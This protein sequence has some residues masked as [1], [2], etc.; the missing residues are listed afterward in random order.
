MARTARLRVPLVPERADDFFARIQP[1]LKD[2]ATHVY[3]DTSF[4]MWLTTIG[5]KSRSELIKWLETA[6]TKR[7]HVPVW[8][9]HEY[10][11]HHSA[12]TIPTMLTNCTKK[13]Q[14]TARQTYRYLRPFLDEDIDSAG[15]NA[16]TLQTSARS[17]LTK[18]DEIARDVCKWERNYASHASEI[19]TLINKITLPNSDVF[20]YM[21]DIDAIGS[22]RF[23]G[24]IPPGFEDRHKKGSP[25]LA[26]TESEDA[27]ESG[28]PSGSN[29][30]G[31]L[32]LWKE[33]LEHAKKVRAKHVVILTNDRKSDWYS[34]IIGE[35]RDRIGGAPM[36]RH[37]KA[38]P[39]AHHM[40][41]YEAELAAGIIDVVL[42]DSPYLGEFL[43]TLPNVRAEGFSDVALL[44]ELPSAQTK[45]SQQKEMLSRAPPTQPAS[46][47]ANDGAANYRTDVVFTL[48][49]LRRALF[50]S[51][52]P[53]PP[54]IAMALEMAR[55]VADY[56]STRNPVTS[57][58][59]LGD[60]DHKALVHFARE[61]H[62]RV[63]AGEA[64]FQD[65]LVDLSDALVRLPVN[66]AGCLYFGLVVASYLDRTSNQP[67][68][69]PRSIITSSLLS[70]QT[71]NFAELPLEAM[72]SHLK[73]ATTRPLYIPSAAR[74][75][76]KA[77]LAVIA[78]AD[79]PPQIGSI[80]I[81]EVEVLTPAQDNMQLRLSHIFP[82]RSASGEQLIKKACEIFAVPYDQIVLVDDFERTFY[83]SD[84]V[85]F[86]VPNSV[87]AKY[88][89]TSDG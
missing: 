3:L 60:F 22:G 56:P 41:R 43:R 55:P 12:R 9:A 74:P 23:A 6:L 30:W 63:L 33:T 11:R 10:L 76:L 68:L 40:L 28:A 29:R 8:A 75:S 86:K 83:F 34:T 81:A 71:A 47:A 72:N 25:A 79:G 16:A 62:D 21:A 65:L 82:E 32:I 1:V 4:L 31:D 18:L 49:S 24:R 85:G 38:V 20:G 89:E 15:P 84:N 13:L 44:T 58:A 46:A 64:G 54:A 14:R 7:F 35:K 52:Q 39:L 5:S 87:S 26:N 19:L 27:K 50:E 73:N 77:Q 61:L 37:L 42:L 48:A 69:P 45:K 66:T 57:A 36:T 51:R 80:R 70:N 67:K 53:C 78:D 59:V 2:K 88:L 17:T